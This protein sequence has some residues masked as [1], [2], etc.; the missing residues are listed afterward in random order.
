MRNVA[1]K[2]SVASASVDVSGATGTPGDKLAFAADAPKVQELR[3]LLVK[4]AGIA[5]PETIAGA[6]QVRGTHHQRARRKRTGSR[7]CA[8]AAW[9]GGRLGSVA[10]LDATGKIAAGGL[11]LDPT[12]NATRALG[13]KV[14][15]TRI[16]IP[17]GEFATLAA[18]ATGTLAQHTANIALTGEGVDGHARFAGAFH[19]LGTPALS[20]SGSLDALDNRGAFAMKLEAPAQIEWTHDQLHVGSA[21]LQVAE[22][23]ADL[24]DLRWDAGKLS[25][26]GAFEGIPLTALLRIAGLRPPLAST[27][28]IAGD[29]SVAATPQL[30]GTVHV[31]RE[32]GD[33][34]GTEGTSETPTAWRWASRRS[35]RRRVSRTTMSPPPPRCAR[36][37]PG[38]P[39]P[40]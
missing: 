19:D 11:T 4:Y 29:W 21:R 33:L 22:G 10:T 20:W 30:N 23:R 14:A 32:R 13:F 5:I 12:A 1:I 25:T 28:V 40:R 17:Q 24:E 16:R 36:S 15:A 38:T 31:R 35:K 9:N 6:L 26:R 18:D 2:A 8:A 34:F 27:L 3:G 37:A 39:T 7:R